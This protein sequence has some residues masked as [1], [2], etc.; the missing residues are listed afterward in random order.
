MKNFN[1]S[2][3]DLDEYKERVAENI[4]SINKGGIDKYVDP[5]GYIVKLFSVNEEQMRFSP[6]GICSIG[7]LKKYYKNQDLLSDAYNT[8]RNKIIMWPKHRQSINQRRYACFRD[9]FDFTIFDIKQ[10]YKKGESKLVLKDSQS[11]Q[12]LKSLGGFKNFILEYQLEIFVKNN[13]IINLASLDGALISSYEDYIFSPEI[14]E[15]YL[16]MLINKLKQFNA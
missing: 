14:N 7:Y 2:G 15:Q 13:D 10:F 9:R 4:K 3:D 1:L 6:D 16:E 5:D 8:I 11:A 12:F